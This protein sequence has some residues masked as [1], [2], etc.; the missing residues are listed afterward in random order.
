MYFKIIEAK[1]LLHFFKFS[2]NLH[3]YIFQSCLLQI[4]CIG[5]RG[6]LKH[7]CSLFVKV[8]EPFPSYRRFLTTLQ[9]TAFRKHSDKRRNCSKRAIS[10]FAT[11]FSTFCH[12]LSIQLWRFSVFWQNTFK[13]VCCRI[14]VWGKGLIKK[15]WTRCCKWRNIFKSHLQ[16]MIQNVSISRKGLTLSYKKTFSDD[17]AAVNFLKT[18]WQKEIL[19]MMSNFSI[20]TI[21]STFFNNFKISQLCRFFMFLP[22]C[23]QNCLLQICCM[24]GSVKKENKN[25]CD[26]GYKYLFFR[27]RNSV[28]FSVKCIWLLGAFSADVLKPNWKA[29][30]GLKLRNLLLSEELR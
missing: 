11:M 9:Q 12:R 13:V 23:F 19:L 27:C 30:Q 26:Q 1:A 8:Y 29:S 14:V 16:W 3:L 5:E 15:S 21:F 24:R 17:S 10:P 25:P 2:T 22:R 6:L 4:S 7:L 18:L 28:E 20:A